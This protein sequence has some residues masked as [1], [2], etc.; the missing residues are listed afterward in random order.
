MINNLIV[1][2][3]LSGST[4]ARK[5]ADSGENV[6]VI[7]KRNHIGGN[8]Y[9]Y[10]EKKTGIRLSKYGAHIFHTNNEKVWEFVNR[11]SEWIPY[12]HRVLSFVKGKYVPV[13]VNIT[14]V[15]MLFGLNITTVEQ[16]REWLS[17]HQVKSE[18]RN[19]RD[20]ALARVGKNLYELMFENYTRKQWDM[21]PSELE[22]SVLERIPVRE[23]FDDRYFSDKYEAMPTNGYTELVRRMLDHP[24]IEVRLNEAYDRNL[25]TADRLFFTGKIDTYFS[26]RFGKLEYRSLIFDYKVHNVKDYQPVAVVNY[27]SLEYPFTRK[28]DYKKFYGIKSNYSIV[29]TEYSISTGEEYYPVPTKKNRDIYSKYQ[30][31]AKKLESK[32]IYFVGRLAEYKYFNMDQAILSALQLYD[33][34][35]ETS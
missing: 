4:L 5:L 6:L 2:S 11:F 18:I 28:I 30:H 17:V 34:I 12:E 1:G 10:I 9:D 25:H 3:G 13:P 20:S 21:D 32:N 33:R 7:D 8:V 24:N 16:M 26:D 23:N 29:A 14:T 27:P 15:N 31:E 35:N 22:P 19:S